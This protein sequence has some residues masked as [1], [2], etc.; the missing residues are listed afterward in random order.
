MKV[1][2]K[3]LEM[4]EQSRG[5]VFSN[6][7]WLGLAVVLL[8]T[9]AGCA[10]NPLTGGPS[11]VRVSSSQLTNSA[12]GVVT[13]AILQSQV[14]RFADTYVAMVSQGCDDITAAT[15]NPS[16]RLVALRWKLQQATAAYNDA[17]GENPSANA[18]D[19]LVLATIARGVV[20][21]YGVTAYGTNAVQP[22]LSA[23]IAMES[24]GWT[25]ASA[26]LSPQQQA[27]LRGLIE[28]W[29]EKFPHQHNVGAIRF[30]EFA[31]ALGQGSQLAGGRPSSIFS[32]LYLNPLSGLD[33]TT[34]AIEGIR[35]LGERT[36]YYT[37]R[38][39]QLLNWQ[40][41]LLIY[42]LARQPESVQMM[43]NMNQF[44]NTAAVLSKTGQQLPQLIN[45]QRQA[46]INQIFANLESQ[47]NQASQLMTNTRATLEAASTA[48]SNINT[49]LLSLTAFVQFVTPTN[50]SPQPEGTNSSPPF[51]ILDYGTAASKIGAMATNVNN[52]LAT[53]NDSMPQIN[54][55]GDQMTANADAVVHQAFIMGLILIVILLVGLVVAGLVYRVLAHKLTGG[56]RKSSETKT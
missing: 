44:A 47:Q 31:T 5:H 23:Q 29:H 27:E 28:Q 6:F 13:S 1:T 56:G 11:K 36:M 48:A 2:F 15:T 45:D 37:Q 24:N 52:L 16:V 41:Q 14:M 22:L 50:S 17:T 42:E 18:L 30:R 38:M 19:L 39:P 7:Y 54:K 43:D 40:T 20:E 9:M 8:L 4:Q 49:A 12:S 21:D 3:R 33:P 51:N 35:Q 55:I 46:A 26:I 25:M 53:A 32:L 10:S 34:A